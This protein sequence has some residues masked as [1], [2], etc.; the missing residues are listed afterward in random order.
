MTPS[1]PPNPI[2]GNTDLAT[3]ALERG[4]TVVNTQPRANPAEL[5]RHQ[6][7]LTILSKTPQESLRT[8]QRGGRSTTV[9]SNSDLAPPSSISIQ[10]NEPSTV[11]HGCMHGVPSASD[12]SR[13]LRRSS[14]HWRGKS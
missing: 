11:T 13:R 1:P 3:G 12:C 4:H 9:F 7:R 8:V 10:P 6:L 5:L 2:S 14:H